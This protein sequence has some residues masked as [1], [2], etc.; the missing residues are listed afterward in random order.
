[1]PTFQMDSFILIFYR[2]HDNDNGSGKIVMVLQLEI[3]SDLICPW[4]Y[5]GK[6]RLEAAVKLAEGQHTVRVTWNPFQ[7]NP[8]MPS[9]GMDRRTY[10]SAKF[11]SWERSQELDAG[12][13]RAGAEVGINFNYA[14]VLRTPNTFDSHRLV[15]LAD[16]YDMQDQVVEALFAAYFV[17]GLDLSQQSVL[18]ETVVRPG[19][20]RTDVEELL[21]RDR[22]AAEVRQLEQAAHEIGVQSVPFYLLNRRYQISGAQP[23]KVMLAA[24]AE[25]ASDTPQIT[26]A[27]GGGCDID[28]ATGKRSC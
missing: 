19:L 2:N 23:P 20:P 5:I 11:G 3:Y 16:Q 22:G 4:C 18:A 26:D 24:F 1:V 27:I 17:E 13:C 8:D 7:L 14:A 21:A 25:V 28:L 12:V 6:R 15:W 10:R 9:A